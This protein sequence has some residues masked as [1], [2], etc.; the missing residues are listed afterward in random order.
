MQCEHQLWL[1]AW[2]G[3]H[4]RE[5][6]LVLRQ[7]PSALPL[8]QPSQQISIVQMALAATCGLV[9]VKRLACFVSVARDD[10]PPF[11]ITTW[12]SEALPTP[13]VLL[14]RHHYVLLPSG[15]FFPDLS[16]DSK[17]READLSEL[18]IYLALISLDLSNEDEVLA[19]LRTYG[20]LGIRRGGG[21]PSWGPNPEPYAGIAYFGFNGSIKRRLIRSVDDALDEILVEMPDFEFKAYRQTDDEEYLPETLT[22]FS[23]GATWLSDLV[24]AWRWISEDLDPPS[25]RCPIW[26]DPPNGE[27]DGPPESKEDAAFFLATGLDL[28]LSPFRPRVFIPAEPGKR[29]RFAPKQPFSEEIPAFFLCCLELFNHIAEQANYKHCRNETCGRLFVKQLGRSTHGQHRKRG[30]K[31]C[32]AECAKAQAQREYRRRRARGRP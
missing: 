7:L 13:V 10:K 12:P 21:G 3:G 14:D 23:Y 16:R 31:Y 8:S 2:H 1:R 25:W 29:P 4:W 28:A 24:T 6:H 17:T 20:P 9:G 27:D 15:G 11:R 19:F 26:T 5:K 30:V 18:E 22:E 32:S